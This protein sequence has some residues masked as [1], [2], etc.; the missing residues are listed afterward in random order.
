MNL[1]QFCDKNPKLSF[2]LVRNLTEQEAMLSFIYY[3]ILY[4]IL[5]TPH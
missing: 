4:V 3:G 5:S 2:Y 1:G